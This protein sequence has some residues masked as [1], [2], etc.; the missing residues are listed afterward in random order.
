[1]QLYFSKANIVEAN[2]CGDIRIISYAIIKADTWMIYDKIKTLIYLSVL[3]T[4]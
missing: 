1:M 3:Y 4:L 2:K